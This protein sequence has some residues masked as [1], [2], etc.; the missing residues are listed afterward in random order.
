[1]KFPI[2]ASYARIRDLKFIVTIR[3]VRDKLL[4]YRIPSL[5]IYISRGINACRHSYV[6]VWYVILAP[7][8]II[9]LG[10]NTSPWFIVD[11]S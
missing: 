1:M 2:V 6:R 10:T 4:F 9:Y 5:V 11:E 7:T 3:T 8:E